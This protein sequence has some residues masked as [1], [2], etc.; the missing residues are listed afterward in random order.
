MMPE[1]FVEN[2]GDYAKK[3]NIYIYIYI[4]DIKLLNIL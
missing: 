3:F 4:Y 2:F 1:K